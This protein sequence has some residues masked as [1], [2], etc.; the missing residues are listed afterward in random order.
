MF[1]HFLTGWYICIKLSR[2]PPHPQHGLSQLIPLIRWPLIFFHALFDLIKPFIHLFLGW[3]EKFLLMVIWVFSILY[4]D[5]E[6]K[7]N[8]FIFDICLNLKWNVDTTKIFSAKV[9]LKGW[10][11]KI[12]ELQNF[13]DTWNRL[14]RLTKIKFDF[15]WIWSHFFSHLLFS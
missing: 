13:H 4:G 8:N 9:Y 5:T 2:L 3:L 7:L 10:M 6:R 12:N 15:P 1:G 14:T 11:C